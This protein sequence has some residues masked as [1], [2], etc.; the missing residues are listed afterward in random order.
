MDIM[1]KT[2]VKLFGNKQ[3]KIKTIGQRQGEKKHEILISRNESPYTYVFSDK[4]YLIQPRKNQQN[5]KKAKKITLKPVS[6]SEF[7]SQNT[8]QLSVEKLESMLRKEAWI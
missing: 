5:I 6:F 4:Y 1:G 7:T 8:D 2:M 3:T